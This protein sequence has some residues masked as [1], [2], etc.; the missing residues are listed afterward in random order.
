MS[1]RNV[2]IDFGGGLEVPVSL[3]VTLVPC[4]FPYG[5]KL[6]IHAE[7][8][9]GSILNGTFTESTT[10]TVSVEGVQLDVYVDVTQHCYGVSFG[11]E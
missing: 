7:A 3:E 10:L 6:N 2:P 11:V 5:V 4:S 1:C 8:F 9:A